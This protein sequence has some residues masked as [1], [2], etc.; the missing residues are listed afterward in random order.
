MLGIKENTNVLL[1]IMIPQT[2]VYVLKCE[3][4][5]NEKHSQEICARD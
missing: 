5:I 2:S 4:V 1:V 3:D